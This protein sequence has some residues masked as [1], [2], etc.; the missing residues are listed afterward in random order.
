MCRIGP[1]YDPDPEASR[2]DMLTPSGCA[3]IPFS[4]SFFWVFL[5]RDFWVSSW[6]SSWVA[7]LLPRSLLHLSLVRALEFL[8]VWAF[9]LALV[10]VALVALALALVALVSL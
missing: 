5:E 1:S 6:V 9:S 8:W 3:A 4:L 2:H 7:S 10:L